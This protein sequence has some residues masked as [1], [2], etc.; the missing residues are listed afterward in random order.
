MSFHNSA[1]DIHLDGDARAACLVAICNNEEG[2]G[3]TSEMH[4]DD[5]L[6]NKDGGLYLVLSVMVK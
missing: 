3:L 2:S 6:G 5:C 4:L 1:C